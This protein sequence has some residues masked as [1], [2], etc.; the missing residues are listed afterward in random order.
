LI[1]IDVDWNV[2]D[3]SIYS[4]RHKLIRLLDTLGA[5]FLPAMRIS[6]RRKL[7]FLAPIVQII[8]CPDYNELFGSSM[9]VMADLCLHE[10]AEI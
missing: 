4:I 7:T 8:N 3:I 6:E 1:Q 5:A 2:I 10:N 9:H